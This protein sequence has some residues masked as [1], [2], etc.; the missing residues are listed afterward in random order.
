MLADAAGPQSEPALPPAAPRPPTATEIFLGFASVSVMAFGGVLPW[1]RRMVVE[2]RRWMTAEE[3]NEAFALCQF[4]PG[5]NI[6][7]FSVVFGSRFGG[8]IGAAAG[9]AGILGPPV[10][11]ALVL[12]VLYGRFGDVAALQRIFA[13]LAA[14]AAGL[15]IAVS[16]KMTEPVLRR[17]GPAPLIA[18]AVFA[19]VGLLRWPL[20]WVLVAATPISLALTWWWRR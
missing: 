5:P 4:L 15:I 6:V 11:I 12:A 10:L 3:F 1:A 8:A 2:R 20:I 14:A 7:N 19:A 9:L 18:L 17:G 13:G 16:I